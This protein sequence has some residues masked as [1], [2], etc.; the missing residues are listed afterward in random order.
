MQLI[1]LHFLCLNFEFAANRCNRLSL[2]AIDCLENNRITRQLYIPS[3]NPSPFI[4]QYCILWLDHT[5]R[6]PSKILADLYN[7]F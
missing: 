3:Q 4:N 2:T 6:V 5:L 7:S 1:E